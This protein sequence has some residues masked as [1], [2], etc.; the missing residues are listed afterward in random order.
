MMTWQCQLQLVI[1]KHNIDLLEISRLLSHRKGSKLVTYKNISL[2]N[3]FVIFIVMAC[4]C[5]MSVMAAKITANSTTLKSLLMLATTAKLVLHITDPLC[6]ESTS[7]RNPPAIGGS[8]PKGYVMQNVLKYHDALIKWVL[9]CTISCL[10]CSIMK[11]AILCLW[12]IQLMNLH[13]QLCSYS[14]H[15]N[16]IVNLCR[17]EKIIH[18]FHFSCDLYT[19]NVLIF[20]YHI[21]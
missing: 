7:L 9:F 2:I 6:G 1:I 15:H 10:H 11:I 5:P 18:H 14:S 19:S 4:E 8:H 17:P 21:I 3:I 16:F 13:Y 20:N 12:I